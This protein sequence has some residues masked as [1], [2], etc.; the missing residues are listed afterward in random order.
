MPR[1][2]KPLSPVKCDAH[3][4]NPDGGN[5]LADG[6]GLYL[7]AMPNGRKSWRLKY[8]R[9]EGKEDRLVFGDYPAVS[10]KMARLPRESIQKRSN[11]PMRRA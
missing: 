8:I 4:Y 2:V 1:I 5:K 9:P 7:E 3:R 10:L 6:G 11:G